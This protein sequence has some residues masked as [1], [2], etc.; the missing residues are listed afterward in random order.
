LSNESKN[1]SLVMAAQDQES[2][3]VVGE[4]MKIS[5]S[6]L[7]EKL[8][9]IWPYLIDGHSKGGHIWIP[10]S[11]YWTLTKKDIEWILTD[12]WIDKYRYVAEGFDCDDSAMLFHAF[13]VQERYKRMRD[14][15]ASGWFSF[16]I[17]Q[18]WGTKFEGKDTSHAINI[19]IT[20]DE[21]VI[22]F[23]P[24][25]DRTWIADAGRDHV[26]FIRM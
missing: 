18:C 1:Q 17:G 2:R 22:L 6:D 3:K 20:S 9:N 8:H 16:A 15:N 26:H 24:Q 12:T 11:S 7:V 23:E 4:I 14:A 19:A 10:D 13:C 5:R 25:N 21:G